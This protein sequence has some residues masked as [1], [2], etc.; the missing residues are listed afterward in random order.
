MEGTVT[1]SLLVSRDVT[2]TGRKSILS[3]RRTLS[4]WSDTWKHLTSLVDKQD[5]KVTKTSKDSFNSISFVSL[6]V[7]ISEERRIQWWASVAKN[8]I[9]WHAGYAWDRV[10]TKLPYMP[11]TNKNPPT[12]PTTVFQAKYVS[13]FSMCS[14]HTSTWVLDNLH[15]FFW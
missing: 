7:F 6:S 12:T 1:R 5:A 14:L 15:Q 9:M 4:R 3:H 13:C 8:E 11:K 2:I 10:V